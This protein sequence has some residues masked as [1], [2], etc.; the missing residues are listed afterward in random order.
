MRAAE[1]AEAHETTALILGSEVVEAGQQQRSGVIYD[2]RSSMAACTPSD[3]TPKHRNKFSP[4]PEEH[5][6]ASAHAS[7]RMAANGEHAN[8]SS[9]EKNVTYA[10]QRHV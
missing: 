9:M 6:R 10:G 1:I 8:T 4:H 2:A 5:A 7:R 3:G